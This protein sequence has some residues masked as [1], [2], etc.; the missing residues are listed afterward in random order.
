MNERDILARL[1]DADPAARVDLTRVDQRAGDALREGILMT[2]RDTDKTTTGRRSR[3]TAVAAGLTLALVGGGTAA[4]IT[5]YR[6]MYEGGGNDGVTCMTTWHDPSAGN[7][8]GERA[9][10]YGGADISGDPIADCAAY[11]EKTGK[12]AIVDP[13]V[14][15]W[16]DGIVVGPAAGRPAEAELVPALTAAQRD[17]KSRRAELD[18][19]LDDY[20]DGGMSKC[21]DKAEDK[22]FAAQELAR[23]GFSGMRFVVEDQS[24]A[25]G[26]CTLLF[27]GAEDTMEV[28]GRMVSMP[29]AG[30]LP[31][32]AALRTQIAD[33]CLTLPQ[34]KAAAEAIIGSDHHWPPST[35]VDSSAKCTRVDFNVA[36]GR[37][38][39]LYGPEGAT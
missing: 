35:T 4:A 8:G 5:T 10:T 36:G 21:F 1:R 38:I 39:F 12:A 18:H 7:E 27:V 23:L 34:A 17:A 30:Q 3:H 11:A 29:S 19:S 33:K 26:D 22:T 24:P 20:V 14:T 6:S 37:Q 32:V 2:N 16:Q 13:V 15:R 9:D 25:E 28:R 31:E